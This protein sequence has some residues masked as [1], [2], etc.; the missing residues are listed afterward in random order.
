MMQTM[1]RNSSLLPFQEKIFR[2]Q[3]HQYGRRNVYLQYI[4]K[5]LRNGKWLLI[6][7]KIRNFFLHSP[8]APVPKLKVHSPV[9]QQSN[10]SILLRSGIRFL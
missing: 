3:L 9:S 2:E 7:K 5:I 8:N 1:K 4:A 6:P 10:H